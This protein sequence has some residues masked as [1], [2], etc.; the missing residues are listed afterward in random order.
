MR[1]DHLLPVKF[2]TTDFTDFTDAPK[3]FEVIRAIR[4]IRGRIPLD[5][6]FVNANAPDALVAPFTAPPAAADPELPPAPLNQQRREPQNT[7]NTRKR[8]MAEIPP[9]FPFC[10][11][12][13]FCGQFNLRGQS[14]RASSGR[15]P[16]SRPCSALNMIWSIHSAI[17]LITLRDRRQKAAVNKGQK[18]RRG[19]PQ[20]GK[21]R[22]GQDEQ[23]LQDRLFRR[24][25][26]AI[27]P[28]FVL[29][30][31][32]CSSIS[33]SCLSCSSCLSFFHFAAFANF[34]RHPVGS[35]CHLSRRPGR[36]ILELSALAGYLRG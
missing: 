13:V 15:H 24:L 20:P 34:R 9:P 30:F 2:L 31:Q 17:L 19:K 36:N 18:T 26:F 35:W 6:T 4:G 27:G 21:R 29:E 3:A 10:V 28:A 22:F 33:K 25:L 23:D 14:S 1:R 11:F 8:G 16:I 7:Q 5:A 32:T 12:G